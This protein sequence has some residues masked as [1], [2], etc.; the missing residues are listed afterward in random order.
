MHAALPIVSS[1]SV[2]HVGPC[3]R[4][5]QHHQ[6]LPVLLWYCKQ[7]CHFL[8][9]F[10]RH[11]L[12]PVFWFML[13]L[14][15]CFLSHLLFLASRVCLVCHCHDYSDT[16]CIIPVLYFSDLC[17]LFSILNALTECSSYLWH[18]CLCRSSFHFLDKL[19][20][21]IIKI[22]SQKAKTNLSNV[23]FKGEGK[24]PCHLHG[25]NSLLMWFCDGHYTNGGRIWSTEKSCMFWFQA[26]NFDL[27]KTYLD[28]ITNYTSVIIMLSRIDDKKALVGMFNCAHE[29][30]NGARWENTSGW[31]WK[32]WMF[33]RIVH[34][35]ENFSKLFSNVDS[36]EHYYVE[37]LVG[38]QDRCSV[39]ILLP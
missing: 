24:K 14:N 36:A 15:V 22:K 33:E 30:T 3:L 16:C 11:N 13:L 8:K 25:L 26:V 4:A 6:R 34:A 21:F 7:L 19:S 27:T 37:T 10:P 1:L 9:R 2:L 35:W 17:L 31:M 29:M 5:A 12:T 32:Q 18:L 23:R 38:F 20:L 39:T 28:L